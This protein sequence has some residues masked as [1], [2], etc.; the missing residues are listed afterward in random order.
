MTLM[1]TLTRGRFGTRASGLA[2]V[3]TL[4]LATAAAANPIVTKTTLVRK[5]SA[6][7]DHVDLR[8]RVQVY[9]AGPALTGLRARVLSNSPS[10]VVLDGTLYFGRIEEDAFKQSI[11][12]FTIRQRRDAPIDLDVLEFLFTASIGGVKWQDDDGDGERDD[13]E[14]GLAG[15]VVYLD[16]N[17]N[18]VLDAGER[19][20]LSQHDDPRTRRNETG[21]FRFVDVEPGT[22]HVREIVPPD[23]FQTFPRSGVH[24]VEARPGD[25]I[26][27]LDLGNQP[28]L[29]GAVTGRK[30]QDANGN[31]KR[32]AGEPGLKG[33]TIY[34]DVNANGVFDAGEPSSLTLPDDPSTSVD[35]SGNFWFTDLPPDRHVVREVVPD[36]FI[37]TFPPA[38]FHS[39]LVETSTTI[40]GLDF[41]N[42][43]RI[44]VSISGTKWHDDNADGRRQED[45]PGLPG[46]TI[47]IDLNRN[48][49]LDA[50]EPLTVSMRDDPKTSANEAG[51]YWLTNLEPG[52]YVVR[53]VVPDGFTQTFPRTRH[54]EIRLEDG[55]V[56]AGLDF[57]NAP[58]RLGAIHGMKWQDEDGDGERDESEPG[59]PG[60]VIYLDQNLNGELDPDEPS[61]VSMRN[62]PRTDVN[63]AGR[64]WLTDVSPGEYTVREV[65]PDG[66]VQTF[67][68]TDA[69]RVRLES[70]DVVSGL[71][72]GNQP[73]RPG[74]IHGTKWIDTNRDGRRDAGEG[75][76]PGVTI[77]LDMNRNG[78]FD[79]PS[80]SS[81]SSPP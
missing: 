23:Y 71:D 13:N 6:G 32:D 34:I 20:T 41:G 70:G 67:P 12:R 58:E 1:L 29:P 21:R 60:V 61:T 15:V 22:V 18:G 75:G 74:S 76:L 53:E 63:E 36:G 3:G 78:A 24:I 42:R 59:L 57:G 45:E 50:S 37:Q 31:G 54:Y 19:T 48:G 46:V 33:V 77:Y 68:A 72:F 56:V 35:E 52:D 51:R 4:L 73:I 43:A 39:V 62:D 17:R 30:W 10:V 66:F 64:F 11:D 8:F 2:I 80:S 5:R 69:H 38:G 47:Y 44:D 7:P 40:A 79:R 27:G 14:P 49:A 16:A 55:D 81:A 25:T 26:E 65:V 9:N 28:L